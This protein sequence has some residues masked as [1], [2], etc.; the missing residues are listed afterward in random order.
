MASTRYTRTEYGKDA[1]IPE[2]STR[3]YGCTL[4]DHAGAPIPLAQISTLTL[5]L[6]DIATG[7][8]IRNALN[9]LNVN[10]GSVELTSGA[11]EYVLSGN[12]VKIFGSGVHEKRLATF[13]LTYASGVEHHELSFYV[14]NLEQ[15]TTA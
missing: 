8:V 12:D 10:G 3:V 9:V 4:L 11:F 1:A 6:V 13:S 2:G 7:T 14:E 5:T 15:I